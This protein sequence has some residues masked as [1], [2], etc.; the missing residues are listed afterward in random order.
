MLS[1][2][3]KEPFA[4]IDCLRQ[5]ESVKSATVDVHIEF[6]CK[7]N[8]LANTIAYRTQGDNAFFTRLVT[9]PLDNIRSSSCIRKKKLSA[10]NV[11]FLK[12]LE[13]AVR[14]I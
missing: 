14:S 12:S 11:T 6:D 7:E 13:F 10:S 4:V 9:S 1:F 3:E 8:V 5:N 2:V